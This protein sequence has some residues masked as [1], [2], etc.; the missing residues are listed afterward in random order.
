MLLLFV[1]LIFD[2]SSVQPDTWHE[3]Y[4]FLLDMRNQLLC[5][6][7]FADEQ[8]KVQERQCSIDDE[9]I[10]ITSNDSMHFSSAS[11]TVS[12]EEFEQNPSSSNTIRDELRFH[13][14]GLFRSLE[15]L[16]GLTHRVIEK[17]QEECVY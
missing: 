8:R 1:E 9:G 6:C 10:M 17:Y 14:Y 7:P 4:S 12:S 5:A 16:I 15:Q 11:S 3:V 2:N 13:Y